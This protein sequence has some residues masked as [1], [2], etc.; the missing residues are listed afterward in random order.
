MSMSRW[1][2][3]WEVLWTLQGAD[4]EELL[5]GNNTASNNTTKHDKFL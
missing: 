3:S 2:E 1:N 4:A 5:C